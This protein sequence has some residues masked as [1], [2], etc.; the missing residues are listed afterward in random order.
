VLRNCLLLCINCVSGWNYVYFNVIQTFTKKKGGHKSTHMGKFNTRLQMCVPFYC[1]KLFENIF[2]LLY[3]PYSEQRRDR[4]ESKAVRDR[5]TVFSMVSA[6]KRSLLV[7][8][9]SYCLVF[10]FFFVYWNLLERLSWKLNN[11]FV[12]DYGLF[13]YSIKIHKDY[14]IQFWWN[15]YY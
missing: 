4:Y 6:V 1:L 2:L 12:F 11:A 7:F 8:H 15:F 14:S 9:S 3:R 5:S 10:F 13:N